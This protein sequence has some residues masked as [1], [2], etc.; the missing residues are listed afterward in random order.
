MKQVCMNLSNAQIK[1]I[2][3]L[4]Q[5]KFRIERNLFLVEGLKSVSEVM[6]SGWQVKEVYATEELPDAQLISASDME[7]I[8]ALTNPS[9]A[10]AV[11]TCQWGSVNWNTPH[12]LYL[13]GIRDPGNLGTIIRT[14]DWMGWNNIVLSADCVEL[15][16]PK[17]IQASMGSLFH[18][19]VC[20]EDSVFWDEVERN[21]FH[22][23]GATLEGGALSGFTNPKKKLLIIGS[24][25][26]GIRSALRHKIKTE[27][28][29]EARG[30]AESLNAGVAAGILMREL[31]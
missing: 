20:R 22:V 5:T 13:D 21:D 1:R 18:V 17:V 27:I 12:I 24:E 25:S 6:Q 29:I 31:Y 15:F 11:V 7:R 9:P 16:N 19:E 26:H 2:K 30:R 3:S 23:I 28:K 10:L 8:S 4:H 14:A